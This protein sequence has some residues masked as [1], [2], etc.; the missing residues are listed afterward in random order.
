M[1][2]FPLIT[3][4]NLPS[5]KSEADPKQ[6]SITSYMGRNIIKALKY[7]IEKSLFEII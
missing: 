7:I 5:S 3:K 1:L 2:F 4:G 6:Y